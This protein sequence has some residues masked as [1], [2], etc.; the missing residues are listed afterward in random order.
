[1]PV[2]AEV[3]AFQGKVSGYKNIVVF[4]RAQYGAVVPNSEAN[5]AAGVSGAMA[6]VTDKLEFAVGHVIQNTG[7]K[8]RLS[9]KAARIY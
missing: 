2:A 4:G 8:V 9:A 5:R 6:K 3:T 7:E 1:M